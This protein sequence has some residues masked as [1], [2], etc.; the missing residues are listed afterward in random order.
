MDDPIEW[1]HDGACCLGFGLSFPRH[2]IVAMASTDPTA[3]V[4]Q[5][6][7]MPA[8]VYILASKKGGTLYTGVTNDIAD[9]AAQ[10]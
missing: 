8:A 1:G 4:G 3:S 9:R 5:W 6:G 2:G 10:P 7:N